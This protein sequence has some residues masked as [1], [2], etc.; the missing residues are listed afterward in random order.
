MLQSLLLSGLA[1]ALLLSTSCTIKGKGSQRDNYEA[2]S[3]ESGDSTAQTPAENEACLRLAEK[4]KKKLQLKLKLQEEG[5]ETA[6]DETAPDEAP[7]E[8]TAEE[9]DCAAAEDGAAAE[10]ESAAEDGATE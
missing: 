1:A 3:A 5:E 8:E 9:K 2:K 6:P 10:D 7:A 4:R